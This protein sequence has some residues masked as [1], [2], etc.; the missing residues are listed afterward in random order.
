M[1][2]LQRKD[3]KQRKTLLLKNVRNNKC[4]NSKHKQGFILFMKLLL[5]MFFSLN[6]GKVLLVIF[7]YVDIFCFSCG[8]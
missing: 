6:D 1:K 7:L 4:L 8:C 3:L 5:S 2:K